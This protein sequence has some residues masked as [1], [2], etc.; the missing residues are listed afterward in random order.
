MVN[1]KAIIIFFLTLLFLWMLVTTSNPIKFN[2]LEEKYDIC[3]VG[4]SNSWIPDQA[5]P[6]YIKSEPFSQ[7]GKGGYVEL[8]YPKQPERPL[9]FCKKN[10]PV[11]LIYK[12]KTINAKVKVNK[13][14]EFNIGLAT[15]GVGPTWNAVIDIEEVDKPILLSWSLEREQSAKTLRLNWL[16]GK[17]SGAGIYFGKSDPTKDLLITIY[18]VYIK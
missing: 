15:K 8:F 12:A 9:F 1:T 13:P 18:E 3:D 10:I 16:P 5:T 17:F 14:G 11:F 7:Q 4:N 6:L 2:G